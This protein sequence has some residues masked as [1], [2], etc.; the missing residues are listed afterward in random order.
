MYIRFNSANVLNIPFLTGEAAVTAVEIE[1]GYLEL[2][3]YY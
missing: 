1:R 3:M 2:I